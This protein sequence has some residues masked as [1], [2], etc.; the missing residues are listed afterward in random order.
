MHGNT[1]KERFSL[2][3]I[4]AVASMAGFYIDEPRVDFDSVD[5][6]L[7]ADF[8]RRPRIEFQAKATSQDLLKDSH[9]SYPLPIKNYDDLRV[10]NSIIPRLLIVL[11]MPQDD[12]KWL[13]HTREELCLRYCAYW[14]SLRGQPPTH[15]VSTE[16]VH[17]PVDNIFCGEQLS[18]L[19]KKAER[20][21]SL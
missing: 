3:F 13:S 18:E 8:G 9:L 16:T 10:D 4:E 6:T 19:M 11:L 17:I 21:E 14:M 5:G 2:A 15:N 20:G 1:M 7:K 12:S